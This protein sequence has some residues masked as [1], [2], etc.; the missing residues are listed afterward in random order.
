MAH[1]YRLA[2]HWVDGELGHLHAQRLRQ[3]ALL[4]QCAL[5][6]QQLRGVSVWDRPSSAQF[7][8]CPAATARFADGR[9]SNARIIS[10]AGGEVM[11]SNLATLSMPSAFSCSTSGARLLLWRGHQYAPCVQGKWARAIT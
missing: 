5:R 7:R 11:K 6:E 10:C 2:Q 4:V 1:G 8:H 9:T 3:L